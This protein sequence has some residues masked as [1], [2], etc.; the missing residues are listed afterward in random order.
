M[1]CGVTISIRCAA[2][3]L[4]YEVSVKAAE[5]AHTCTRHHL[6]GWKDRPFTRLLL[7]SNFVNMMI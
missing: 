1:A 3:C 6:F 5:H 7:V 4:F 2:S